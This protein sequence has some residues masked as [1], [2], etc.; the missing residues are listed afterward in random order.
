[1]TREE[2]LIEAVVPLVAAHLAPVQLFDARSGDTAIRRLAQR[3]GRI[4]RLVRVA[5]ADQRGRPPLI[6]DRF[7]AGEWLLER[8]RELAI[9]SQVP[10]AIVMGRHLIELGLEPGPAFGSI[11]EECFNR[12]IDGEFNTVEAGLDCAREI[13]SR[14]ASAGTR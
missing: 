4:D 13:L 12:Q 1:M 5:S 10:R 14:D 11:L 8:A 2:G 9:E 3:V 7:D 6:V